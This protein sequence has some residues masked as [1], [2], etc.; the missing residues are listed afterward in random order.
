LRY[1]ASG[2]SRHEIVALVQTDSNG[3]VTLDELRWLR[4]FRR[5]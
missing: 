5:R 2:E 3:R 1:V 4:D